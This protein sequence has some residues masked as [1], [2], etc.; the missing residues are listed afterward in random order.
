M[1]YDTSGYVHLLFYYDEGEMQQALSFI[2]ATFDADAEED[3][4][5]SD[6]QMLVL[7]FRTDDALSLKQKR[8]LLRVTNPDEHDLNC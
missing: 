4:T 2:Q 8:V 7:V 6:G 1:S 5:L 3:E